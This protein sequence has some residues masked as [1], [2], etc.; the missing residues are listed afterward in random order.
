MKSLI[1]TEGTCNQEKKRLIYRDIAKINTP[2]TVR[3]I[4]IIITL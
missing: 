2:N 3:V 1:L 4:A